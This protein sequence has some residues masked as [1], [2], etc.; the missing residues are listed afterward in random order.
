MEEN[1]VVLKQSC[2][3]QLLKAVTCIPN[4]DGVMFP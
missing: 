3:S 1:I 2:I 4:G